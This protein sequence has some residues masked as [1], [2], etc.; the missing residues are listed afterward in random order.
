MIN[1]IH[2]ILLECNYLLGLVNEGLTKE[3]LLSDETLQR[4][5]SRSIEIIGEATK[6]IDKDFRREHKDIEW[7]EMAG[8]RDRLIHNYLGVNYHIVWDVIVHKIPPLAQNIQKI[9]DEENY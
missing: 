9:I 5:V 2:H 8:M 1:F 4:A 7:K 6:N 3:E